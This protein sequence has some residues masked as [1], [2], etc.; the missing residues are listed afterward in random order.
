MTIDS[1]NIRLVEVSMCVDIINGDYNTK[2]GKAKETQVI[3]RR[4]LHFTQGANINSKWM[5]KGQVGRHTLFPIDCTPKTVNF[6]VC[7]F[8]TQSTLRIFIN[9]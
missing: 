3:V 8:E 2:R 1:K 5:S 9:N 4:L 7:K 6:T